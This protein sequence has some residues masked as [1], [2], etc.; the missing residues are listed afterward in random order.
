MLRRSPN[1]P[2]DG[3]AHM[4]TENQSSCDNRKAADSMARDTPTA[5]AE[6]RP[7]RVRTDSTCSPRRIADRQPAMPRNDSRAVRLDSSGQQ[8]TPL[9]QHFLPCRTPALQSEWPNASE[10]SPGNR[11]ENGMDQRI[12]LPTSPSR[13]IVAI[14]SAT[15]FDRCDRFQAAKLPRTPIAI[16]RWPVTPTIVHLRR[17]LAEAVP[18]KSSSF[19]LFG[20]SEIHH[21]D[22]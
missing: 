2:P 11:L 13:C 5:C 9:H 7:G 21:L 8:E 16:W 10:W 3:T 18:G 15:Q 14:V 12:A 19:I 1:T 20:E 17:G 22:S 4:T 6:R